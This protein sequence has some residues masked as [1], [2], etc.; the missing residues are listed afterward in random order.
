[1]VPQQSSSLFP[2]SNDAPSEK[3][4]VVAVMSLKKFYF[5]IFLEILLLIKPSHFH[6]HWNCFQFDNRFRRN[7]RL[8]L[9]SIFIFEMSRKLIEFL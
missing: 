5:T 3:S 9:F 6:F 8:I 1:M 2:L 4:N 7:N